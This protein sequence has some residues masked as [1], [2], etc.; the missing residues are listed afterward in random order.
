MKKLLYFLSLSVMILTFSFITSASDTAGKVITSSGN[1]NVRSTPSSSG[2]VITSVKRATWLTVKDKSGD[3]Y[4]VEFADGK[5]GWCNSKYI[6]LYDDT[7]EMTVDVS[8][9]KLN[10]RSGSGTSHSVIDKLSDGDSV[11]ILYGNSK[12][13]RILYSGNKIGYAATPYLKSPTPSAY[14]AVKLSVPSYKQT[15]SRWSS[16]PI[17]SYGDNIGTIGC[18]TTALA[19]TESYHSG[20][21]VTPDMMASRLSYSASGSLYWPSYYS[22]ENADSSYLSRI[23]SLLK[24]G[25]PVVFGAKKANGSQHWVT[26]TGYN[27]S[28]DSLSEANFTINDPGSK[29]RTLL[30]EFMASYPNAYRIVS[31][32]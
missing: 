18:T 25:K 3:W 1:L 22:V 15:D 19:M 23:Y 21:T 30:S 6:R 10:V 17:G 20:T 14:T 7:Y 29:T 32:K 16:Y 28:T 5:F 27:K 9:G 13:S 11:V 12:W 24:A 31:R 2:R 4:K 8:S 26:V